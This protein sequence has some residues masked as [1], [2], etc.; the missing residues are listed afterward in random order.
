[1]FWVV[2]GTAAPVIALANVVA[3]SDSGSLRDI[4]SDSDSLDA[5]EAIL[6]GRHPVRNKV[7]RLVN[8][9]KRVLKASYI[10]FAVE[11]ALLLCSLLSFTYGVDAIPPWVA[12]L[13]MTASLATVGVTAALISKSSV[14]KRLLQ[15]V[16][17]EAS[18]P[19]KGSPT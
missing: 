5:V 3:I 2:A 11:A 1:M 16:L 13:L 18:P 6:L 15:G 9:P 19:T 10:N 17:A 14:F 7:A 4:L 12:A 8:M